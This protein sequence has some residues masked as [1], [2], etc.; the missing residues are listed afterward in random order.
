MIRAALQRASILLAA[1]IAAAGCTTS[2]PP[3]TAQPTGPKITHPAG[4]GP[5]VARAEQRA[6]CGTSRRAIPLPAGFVAA[7]AVL[8]PLTM[9]RLHGPAHVV[10]RKQVAGHGL[11][12]LVAALRRPPEHLPPGTVCAAQLVAVPVLFLISP[13]GQIIRPVIPSDG[14]GRPQQQVLDALQRLP[15]VAMHASGQR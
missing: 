10:S 6:Q 13:A 11:A 5:A 1:A 7:A 3:K 9:R 14:C 2:S 4:P 12:P 15:W 8:C